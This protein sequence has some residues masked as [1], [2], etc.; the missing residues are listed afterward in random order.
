MNS[1]PNTSTKQSMAWVVE[2]CGHALAI[3]VIFAIAIALAMPGQTFGLALS[4]LDDPQMSSH[5]LSDL[6]IMLALS[7][8]TWAVLFG[9]LCWVRDA[10]TRRKRT[11]VHRTVGSIATETLIVMPVFLLLTFGIAQMGVNSMAGLLTTVGT[12]QAAR[13]VAVWAPEQGTARTNSG[14]TVTRG[15]VEERARIAAAAVVAPVAPMSAGATRC[16]T[17]RTLSLMIQSMVNAG[18]S[19]VQAP[20]TR[21]GT[22]TEA[23]D[24]SSFAQRGPTK[25]VAAYCGMNV[26]FSGDIYT[27]PGDTEQGEFTTRVTY[28][29]KMVFPLVGPAFGGRLTAGGWEVPIERQYRM[30]HHLTPNPELPKRNDIL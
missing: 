7:T 23:L 30:H 16:S 2:G 15:D 11:A 12:F 28:N 20:A 29:H 1:K 10:S 27:S 4:A 6:A 13:T 14:Q 19:P 26:R 24:R 8:F 18:L 21:I 22:F 3:S 17:P 25:L 5:V 9:G